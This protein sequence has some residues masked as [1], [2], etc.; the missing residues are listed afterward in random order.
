MPAQQWEYDAG[1]RE[2]GGR[3]LAPRHGESRGQEESPQGR[4]E[5]NA[6]GVHAPEGRHPGRGRARAQD[7]TGVGERGMPPQGERGNVGEPALSV[8]TLP[9]E[10]TGR[11]QALAWPGAATRS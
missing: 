8:T 1:V 5:G 3:V 10:G 9:E 11:P 7:T 2:E 6:D 4:F